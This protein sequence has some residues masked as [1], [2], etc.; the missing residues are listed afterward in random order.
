MLMFAPS[1]QLDSDQ[2]R[3]SNTSFLFFETSVEMEMEVLKS[4]HVPWY[5]LT[6]RLR[7]PSQERTEETVIHR[8]EKRSPGFIICSDLETVS[9]SW[10][11]GLQLIPT[12]EPEMGTTSH[13]IPRGAW[14]GT[15]SPPRVSLFNIRALYSEAARRSEIYGRCSI[16]SLSHIRE[17]T[18][19]HTHRPTIYRLCYREG[20]EIQRWREKERKRERLIEHRGEERGWL[21]KR[22]R[23]KRWEWVRC[24][25][26]GFSTVERNETRGPKK[27]R[28]R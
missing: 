26:Q 17:N 2:Y 4:L 20:E 22:G 23:E 3:T 25:G 27:N 18:D 19:T 9:S 24:P 13:L 7:F 15:R 8:Y 10:E 21:G 11:P 16:R 14:Q 1:R 12:L 5:K 6:T 28:N